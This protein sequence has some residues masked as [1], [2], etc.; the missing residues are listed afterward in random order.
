V[1]KRP[2]TLAAIVERMSQEHSKPVHWSAKR[3]F[4]RSADLKMLNFGH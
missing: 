4:S 1:L 3:S 2:A